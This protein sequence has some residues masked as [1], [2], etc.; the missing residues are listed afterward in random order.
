MKKIS[1]CKVEITWCNHP[2]PL[3]TSFFSKFYVLGTSRNS[4]SS[5]QKGLCSKEIPLQTNAVCSRNY[6]SRTTE[7]TP[8]LESD[9]I[10]LYSSGCIT[11]GQMK[12]AQQMMLESNDLKVMQTSQV[13][14]RSCSL[15]NSEK[16]QL[17]TLLTSTSH[18]ESFQQNN[19][20]S[21]VSMCLYILGFR[22]A[23][24]RVLT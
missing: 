16:M 7:L 13:C 14:T 12:R 23:F 6:L 5:S 8:N 20:K 17:D 21:L 4:T 19:V 11:R 24:S 2:K 22:D 9:L 10:S 15:Q 3:F 1:S 18:M